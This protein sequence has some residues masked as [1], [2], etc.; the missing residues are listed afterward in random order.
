MPMPLH[1][2]TGNYSSYGGERRSIA[3]ETFAWEGIA[4]I[5]QETIP[6]VLRNVPIKAL[7][8]LSARL[9]VSTH[10]LTQVF[11][12]EPAGQGRGIRQI[13]EHH[14][15]LPTLSQERF[16]LPLA[17]LCPPRAL[18]CSACSIALASAVQP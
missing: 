12:V 9:L 7:H 15:Q 13:A 8:Y 6:E 2:W 16:D 5:D 3:R 10:H 14:R 17:Q 4:E 1:V 11:R 18:D